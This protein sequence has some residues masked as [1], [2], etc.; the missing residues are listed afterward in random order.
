VVKSSAY[1]SKDRGFDSTCAEFSFNQQLLRSRER[2]L[3]RS[4]SILPMG[5][6]CPFSTCDCAA[7]LY[8]T[9]CVTLGIHTSFF[10]GIACVTLVA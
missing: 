8:G 7:V 6:C 10:Y 5:E 9:T 2:S 3:D 4:G 1:E